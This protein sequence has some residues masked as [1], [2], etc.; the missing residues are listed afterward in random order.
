MNCDE[1]IKNTEYNKYFKQAFWNRQF[2]LHYWKNYQTCIQF[3]DV[4]NFLIISKKENHVLR[5][6]VSSLSSFFLFIFNLEGTYQHIGFIQ[7]YTTEFNI[8]FLS[9]YQPINIIHMHTKKR[10][11]FLLT[12]VQFLTKKKKYQNFQIANFFLSIAFF[13]S[14]FIY[15]SFQNMIPG[16][17]KGLVLLRMCNEMLRRLSK[18]K[19]TVFCGRILMFLANSFPLGERSGK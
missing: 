4:N 18:E 5:W 14:H 16:R 9:I 15:L 7:R 13:F 8:P 6:L 3:M 10:T 1:R 19:N 12:Y 2:V 17:G 11:L